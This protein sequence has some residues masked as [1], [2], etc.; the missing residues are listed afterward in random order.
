[1]PQVPDNRLCR[2][3]DKPLSVASA[4][5]AAFSSRPDDQFSEFIWRKNYATNRCRLFIWLAHRGRLFTNERRFR[6][7]LTDSD[8]CPFCSETESTSHM[9]IHCHVAAQAWMTVDSL[10]INPSDC[11][12]IQ[13]LQGRSPAC[14]FRNTVTMSILWSLWNRRNAK[15]FKQEDESLG[16]VLRRASQDLFLWAH[17]CGKENRKQILIDWGIMLSRLDVA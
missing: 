8:T 9:L 10:N 15:V 11:S 14:N 16:C 7:D 6:R 12:S 17:R 3:N 2:I 13:D 5:G 4:Y 1:M